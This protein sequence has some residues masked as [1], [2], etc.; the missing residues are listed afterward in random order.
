MTG[1]VE[2]YHKKYG[3]GFIR[4][5]DGSKVFFSY[6]DIVTDDHQEAEV[7]DKVS[8]NP[9]QDRKGVRGYEVKIEGH[10]ETG[11]GDCRNSSDNS[12]SDDD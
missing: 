2:N 9:I 8:F 3:Y 11:G 5:E 7:G 1:T 4:A 6:R 10:M 12:V